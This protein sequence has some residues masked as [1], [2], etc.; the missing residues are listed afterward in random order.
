MQPG[1]IRKEMLLLGSCLLQLALQLQR[2]SLQ[3]PVLLHL[4]FTCTFKTC[5][6]PEFHHDQNSRAHSFLDYYMEADGN[7]F[8][9][10]LR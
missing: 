5:A 1:Q 6:F 7:L 9:I 3:G 8:Q 4:D 2:T 10:L